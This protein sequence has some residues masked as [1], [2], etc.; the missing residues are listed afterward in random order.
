MNELPVTPTPEKRDHAVA[1]TAIIATT[2]ILLVCIG[3][4]AAVFVTY[5]LNSA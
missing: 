4:C 3:S 2:I 5:I 1:I